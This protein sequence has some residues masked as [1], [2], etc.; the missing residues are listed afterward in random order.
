MNRSKLQQQVLLFYREML[1]FAN[2]KPEV[3][4]FYKASQN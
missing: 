4:A 3:I 2:T 1:K